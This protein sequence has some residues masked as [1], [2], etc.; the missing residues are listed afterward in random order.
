MKRVTFYERFEKRRVEKNVCFKDY[1]L[2]RNPFTQFLPETAK[3]SLVD[4]E[5]QEESFIENFNRLIDGEI[6]HVFLRAKRGFGKSHFLY[7]L[8]KEVEESYEH[9]KIQKPK[10]FDSPTT[11]KKW[12]KENKSSEEINY[13]FIDDASL[14]SSTSARMFESGDIEYIRTIYKNPKIKTISAWQDSLEIAMPFKIQPS[15]VTEAFEDIVLPA[16]NKEDEILLLKRRI[17]LNS[18][19]KKAK[20]FFDKSFFEELH[21]ISYGNPRLLLKNA[22]NCFLENLG[23]VKKFKDK[24]VINYAKKHGKKTTLQMQEVVN[25]LNP[26][27]KRILISIF[28][29][30][31]VKNKKD[32]SLKEIARLLGIT[33]PAIITNIPALMEVGLIESRESSGLKKLYSINPQFKEYL[34]ERFKDDIKIYAQKL[35]KMQSKTLTAELL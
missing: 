10:F 24:Q 21:T 12:L 7:Y 26:S 1:D 22:S 30:T 18:I 8:F 31:L 35:R 33:K 34:E 11:V 27:H 6:S 23:K 28:A 4:R 14:F 13:F 15:D 17:E 29:I 32:C 9:M 25:K 20:N 3:D 19:S 5:K 2:K 16:L